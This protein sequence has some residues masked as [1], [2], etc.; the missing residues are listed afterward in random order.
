MLVKL[1]LNIF[2]KYLIFLKSAGVFV[3]VYTY[4][5]KEIIGKGLKVDKPLL[6]STIYITFAKIFKLC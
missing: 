6:Y 1:V 5:L 2:I 4:V 3:M